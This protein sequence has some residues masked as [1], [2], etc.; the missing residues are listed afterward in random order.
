MGEWRYTS[1]ILELGTSSK[2][3]ESFTPRPLH[4]R[5]KDLRYPIDRRLDVPQDL[6]GRCGE[7]KNLVLSVQFVAC[8]FTDI[9]TWLLDYVNYKFFKVLT[10]IKFLLNFN[11]SWPCY[12]G[13]YIPLSSVR[14]LA[15]Y[16][17]FQLSHYIQSLNLWVVIPF[18]IVGENQRFPGIGCFH[19]QEQRECN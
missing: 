7:E 3:L 6:F 2:W 18:S 5:R 14:C 1:T 17:A 8:C 10:S 9:A 16:Y 19:F 13:Q 15:V 12:E 11:S 4:S